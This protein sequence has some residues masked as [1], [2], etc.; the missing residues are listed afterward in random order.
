MN[1]HKYYLIFG[2]LCLAFVMTGVLYVRIINVAAKKYNDET[3]LEFQ[4]LKK[5][6]LNLISIMMKLMNLIHPMPN[7]SWL[8]EFTYL[9]KL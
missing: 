8:G 7:G 3:G 5:G 1:S 9:L 4:T 2:F 6:T